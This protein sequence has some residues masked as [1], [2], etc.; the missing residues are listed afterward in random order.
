M[1]RAAS[2]RRFA[3]AV[4][5]IAQE[6]NELEGWQGDLEVM[7]GAVENDEFTGLLDAPHV[8]TA[9]KIN[10]IREALG[11]SVG[12][13]A[14]NLLSILASRGLAHQL[15]GIVDEYG[16]LLDAHRGIERA[17]VVTAL[18]LDNNQSSRI[19]GL[20]EGMTGS[21]GPHDVHGGV[22]DP[23]RLDRSDRRPGHRRK[24]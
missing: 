2:P 24:R 6:S 4:F 14:L 16:R 12:H 19:T 3:Q 17:E 1:P 21:A 11:D 20:L 22:P 13:L 23:R 5:Q 18:P 7:A 9:V 10:A 8:P 15:H